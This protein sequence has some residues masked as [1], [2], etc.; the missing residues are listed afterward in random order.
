M[1]GLF[2]RKST[3]LDAIQC[4]VNI[5]TQQGV[6]IMA[7]IDDLNAALASILAA[8]GTV[9]TEV[10]DLITKLQNMPPSVD[11][12]AAIAQANGILAK[13]QAIP[14]EPK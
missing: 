1:L 10:Q 7:Q 3:Q 2:R 12:T 11:L 9:G 4:A 6:K 8:V 5:L 13:L 14:P